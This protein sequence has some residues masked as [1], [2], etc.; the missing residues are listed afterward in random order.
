MRGR[1]EPVVRHPVGTLPSGANVLAMGD[2]AVTNDPIA[3]QGANMA[4][5]AARCYEEAIVAQGERPFDEEFMHRAFDRFWARARHSTRFSNDLLAP[6]PD[7][8]LETLEAAQEYPEVAHRF[9]H[10]FENPRDYSAWLAQPDKAHAYL[11]KVKG[12]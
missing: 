7:H 10:L 2:T 4:S 6:P 5:Y 8:V 3:G 11:E 12:S 9:A 1:V